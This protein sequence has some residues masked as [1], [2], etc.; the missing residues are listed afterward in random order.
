MFEV[1][2]QQ[3][4]EAFIQ[5]GMIQREQLEEAQV[6][7]QRHGGAIFHHFV[8]LN[9]VNEEQILEVVST[10]TGIA[11]VRLSKYQIKKSAIDKI[12]K[13]LAKFHHVVP[14][15][16]LGDVLTVAMAEP[17]DEAVLKEIQKVTQGLIV[18][19]A[20]AFNDQM[21]DAGDEVHGVQLLGG[22]KEGKPHQVN[23]PEEKA[24]G[25]HA[26]SKITLDLLEFQKTDG[27]QD[28]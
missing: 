25:Q 6:R 15:T 8:D 23:T 19:P 3:L 9:F 11:P 27:C 22:L 18:V 14:V 1:T 4:Q 26:T 21:Q 5:R 10:E 13:E 12:P 20:L 2:T 7:H 17:W 24:N 16:E 28:A